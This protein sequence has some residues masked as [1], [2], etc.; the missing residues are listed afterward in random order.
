MFNFWNR[1]GRSAPKLRRAV[2]LEVLEDRVVPAISIA[3]STP[4][5][6]SFNT[7]ITSGTNQA[8]TNDSTL[9]GWFLFN[10]NLAAISTYSASDGSSHTGSF[11][12]FG[13]GTNIDRALGGTASGGAYFGTPA[14]G[15]PAGWIAVAF[16]KSL[17]NN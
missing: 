10:K 5:T 15:A 17:L 12:S 11:Y 1:S 13:T 4:Y 14:S 9:P 7:L 16:I 3:D 8:W 6:Q 2:S